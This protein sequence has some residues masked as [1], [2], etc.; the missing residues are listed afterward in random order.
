[1]ET[2]YRKTVSQERGYPDHNGLFRPVSAAKE[3]ISHLATPTFFF[4][5]TMVFGDALVMGDYF[6]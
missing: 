6:F 2:G 5:W 3:D 1:M 4:F